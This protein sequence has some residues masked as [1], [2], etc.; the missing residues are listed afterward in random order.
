MRA[1][2]RFDQ[3]S[4][5]KI[6]KRWCCGGRHL[7]AA[8]MQSTYG[9]GLLFLSQCPPC[10]AGLRTLERA[11]FGRMGHIIIR[12]VP[13]SPDARLAAVDQFCSLHGLLCD[14]L[15]STDIG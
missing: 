1:A 12:Q 15:Q 3:I 5:A 2:R 11:R 6:L 10:A 14:W 4:Q 7:L 8:V 9:W 13:A